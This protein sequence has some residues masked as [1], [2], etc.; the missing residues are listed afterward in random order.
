MGCNYAIN[1][2]A[3]V[4]PTDVRWRKMSAEPIAAL[5]RYSHSRRRVKQTRRYL[6]HKHQVAMEYLEEEEE[7]RRWRA[8][9]DMSSKN[10]FFLS[11]SFFSC[12]FF[13]LREHSS[14][15]TFF[16]VNNMFFVLSASFSGLEIL[17]QQW[18]MNWTF[19]RCLIYRYL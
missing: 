12:F 8:G 2:L 16:F 19:S 5:Y 1:Y 17:Y 9:H 15:L 13:F 10:V 4:F 6:L 18:L 11:F 3:F 14:L 7:K